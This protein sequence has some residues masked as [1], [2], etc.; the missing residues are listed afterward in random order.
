M[1]NSMLAFIYMQ[2]G[3]NVTYIAYEQVKSF[4]LKLKE[5]KYKRVV[6]LKKEYLAKKKLEEEQRIL[7]EKNYTE[8]LL[9]E[10]FAIPSLSEM[11]VVSEMSGKS[12]IC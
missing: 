1:G 11:S 3:V 4:I 6:K 7:Q 5:M 12:L 2:C 8:K 10:L 9:I